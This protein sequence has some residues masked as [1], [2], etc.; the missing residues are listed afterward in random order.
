MHLRWHLWS[1]LRS[2]RVKGMILEI[3]KCLRSI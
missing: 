3:V 2:W 1:W